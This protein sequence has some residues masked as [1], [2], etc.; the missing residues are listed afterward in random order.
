MPHRCLP[1]ALLSLLLTGC[2]P[3][4]QP[5]SATQSPAPAAS[6]APVQ[7]P[8]GVPAEFF[9]T[10]PGTRWTYEV[11][12]VGG[13]HPLLYYE[14]R[15]PI[16]D[17]HFAT[18]ASRSTPRAIHDITAPAAAAKYQLELSV[19]EGA[20]SSPQG[21]ELSIDADELGLFADVQQVH[22]GVDQTKRYV[23][24]LVADLENQ[25]RAT[26][27]WFF[28]GLP[29]HRLQGQG[30]LDALHFVAVE[31]DVEGWSGTECLHFI[32]RVEAAAPDSPVQ[33]SAA[34]TEDTWFAR[35]QGLVRL[36]QRADGNLM[37]VWRLVNFAPGAEDD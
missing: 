6:P 1:A 17:G 11:D 32:R 34:F 8:A 4:N 37:M 19:Q 30:S 28:G 3:D 18:T 35:D 14:I 7:R 26:R 2:L 22:W 36:E 24:T 25:G 29:G 12:V 31:T 16:G 13:P 9:P 23:V 10:A 20:A 15:R 5:P 33:L 27:V 21:I